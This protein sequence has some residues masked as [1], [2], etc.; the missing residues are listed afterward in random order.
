M[1]WTSLS[2][3]THSWF[4]SIARLRVSAWTF[5]MPGR[6]SD[7]CN[8][9]KE[10][11]LLTYKPAEKEEVNNGLSPTSKT[12]NQRRIRQGP[13]TFEASEDCPG[14]KDQETPVNSGPLQNPLLLCNKEATFKD[15]T[16]PA[17]SVRIHT[18]HPMPPA[19]DSENQ[20]LREG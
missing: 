12:C 8:L 15:C 4:S 14:L 11:G 3:R 17:G 2:C 6:K 18:L 7:S 1:E 9:N 19:R 20:H 10:E 16:F 5:C 13:A